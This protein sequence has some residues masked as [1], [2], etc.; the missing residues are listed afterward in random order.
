MDIL[1]PAGTFKD[2]RSCDIAWAGGFDFSPGVLDDATFVD[3]LGRVV[4]SSEGR[5]RFPGSGNPLHYEFFVVSQSLPLCLKKVRIVSEFGLSPHGPVSGN[6]HRA[7]AS[8]KAPVF[9]RPL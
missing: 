1:R 6:F 2:T 3:L 9:R 7:M 4:A 5:A 8:L